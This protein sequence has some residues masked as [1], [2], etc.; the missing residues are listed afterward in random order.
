MI[1]SDSIHFSQHPQRPC[2]EICIPVTGSWF[3]LV[4]AG[5]ICAARQRRAN[6]LRNAPDHKCRHGGGRWH[7]RHVRCHDGRQQRDAQHATATHL[8]ERNPGRLRSQPHGAR[9]DAHRPAA[10]AARRAPEWRRCHPERRART[11]RSRADLLGLLADRAQ[12]P[13][14]GHRLPRAG[15][16]G[17]ARNH[18]HGAPKSHQG[19]SSG[20]E[21]SLPPRSILWPERRPR[22][23]GHP[24]RCLGG[25]RAS[26][27]GQLHEGGHPL[28]PYPG[29]GLPRTDEPEGALGKPQGEPFR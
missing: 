27:Q 9:R 24:G 19:K 18:G 2:H 4:V 25:R 23:Q 16:Q 1:Q 5:R 14:G 29:A 22:F 8:A 26:G 28:Q 21:T 7:G 10:P 15:R 12:G 11:G 3:S 13:A 6:L 17:S 20:G